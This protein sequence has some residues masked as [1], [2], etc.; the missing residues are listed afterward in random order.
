[1]PIF[2]FSRHLSN[3][4]FLSCE[5]GYIS[6]AGEA[7]PSMLLLIKCFAIFQAKNEVLKNCSAVILH[8]LYVNMK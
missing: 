6:A 5:F 7:V 1:V 2:F 3:A 8:D 4:L